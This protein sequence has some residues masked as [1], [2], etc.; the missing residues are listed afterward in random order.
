MPSQGQPLNSAG[1]VTCLEPPTEGAGRKETRRIQLLESHLAN[2]SLYITTTV[3]PANRL[4]WKH[5]LVTATDHCETKHR[6][7]S[8][9]RLATNALVS[10]EGIGIQS[11]PIYLLSSFTTRRSQHGNLLTRLSDLLC[12]HYRYSSAHLIML[13]KLPSIDHGPIQLLGH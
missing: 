9:R 6:P 1:T 3:D 4:E 12:S 8:E 5:S 13:P 10:R 7:S 11:L 2:R